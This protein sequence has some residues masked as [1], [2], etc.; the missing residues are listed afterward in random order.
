MTNIFAG[1][2]DIKLIIDGDKLT[3]LPAAPTII[4]DSV[5]VPV[6]EILEK[7]D[8]VLD[9]KSETKEL[10]ITK[11]DTIVLLKAGDK[12]ANV[13]GEEK[14]LI[15]P[16]TIIN[17][18]LMIPVRFIAET[19]G[20]SV[21]WENRCVII[22]TN[23]SDEQISVAPAEKNNQTARIT[24]IEIGNGEYKIKADSKLDKVDKNILDGNR[25]VI[26][27]KNC[28]P[29]LNKNEIAVNDELI[30]KIRIAQ[31]QITPVK[32]TR[33]V[34]DM[35]NNFPFEISVGNDNS[36]LVSYQQKFISTLKNISCDGKIITLEKDSAQIDISQLNQTDD[37]CNKKYEIQFPCNIED[38]FGSG[39][40]FIHN[41]IFSHVEVKNDLLTIHENKIWTYEISSDEKNIYIKA[42]APK[43][44]YK[45][46]LVIDAGHGGTDPG[47]INNSVKEK[48]LTFSIVKK[49]LDLFDG[50]ENVKV[51]ST[52]LTDVKIPLDD[53][54]KMANEIG[55]LFISVHINSADKNQNVKGTEV[56][57]CKDI[58]DTQ[59][60]FSS[61][62]LASFL[63]KNLI[64]NLGSVDRKVKTESYVVLKKATVPAALCEIGFITNPDEFKNLCDE[65]YQL[66]AANAIYDCVLSL[67]EN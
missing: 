8:A 34:F 51:Y 42:M 11:D 62:Q 25:L 66:K 47:T 4:N 2:S 54:I 45:N 21:K 19:F 5:V 29:K 20:F 33:I 15:A 61:K 57:Y 30:S 14:I 1:Q 67:I 39:K 56:Y 7:F 16:A 28:E 46:V 60:R 18:K 40:Y 59:K 55:D 22:N 23:S 41:E 27:I 37:Y 35:K 52:R 9:W 38:I 49:I 43:E 63:L 50:N 6:R 10:F 31:N 13:N 26:D 17:D 64:A 36:I 48:D 44:K 58:F 3:N 65:A 12:I 53:R 32:I 24:E